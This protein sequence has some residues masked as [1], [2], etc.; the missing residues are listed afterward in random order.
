MKRLFFVACMG[1]ASFVAQANAISNEKSVSYKARQT[2]QQ[3]Y[4]AV[5]NV[6][7]KNMGN[8]MAKAVFEEDGKEVTVF[9]QNDGEL[10]A[11]T[12]ALL[13]SQLPAKVKAAIQK[14]S[15][16]QQIQE[17]F[18]MEHSSE[19]AY[20]FSI[21]KSGSKKVYRALQ[22]GSIRDVSKSVL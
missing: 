7:W 11:S 15:A 17:L 6:T 14:I 19:S 9:L 5:Q 22:N 18:Y 1:I 12:V 16:N 3:E 8:D 13:P 21:E 10:V 4:G 2:F 20:Y